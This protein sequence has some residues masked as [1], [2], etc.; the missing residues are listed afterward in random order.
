MH[1]ITSCTTWYRQESS[2]LRKRYKL[3]AVLGVTECRRIRQQFSLK[4]NILMSKKS[5]EFLIDL[6]KRCEDYDIAFKRNGYLFL[7]TSEKDKAI[8][9]ANN[10]T[11]REAG[12]NWIHLAGEK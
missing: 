4:E 5:V 1:R 3:P 8:L 11:Q 12:V 10:R 7:G 9:E 6:Q 2:S